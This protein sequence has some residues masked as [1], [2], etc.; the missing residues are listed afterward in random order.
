MGYVVS[1]MQDNAQG[2]ASR[3]SS[4][5]RRQSLPIRVSSHITTAVII[6]PM[7][8]VIEPQTYA[9]VL[10][11]VCW[12]AGPFQPHTIYD[13]DIRARIPKVSSL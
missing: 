2:L 12:A 9:V 6:L 1:L 7:I 5:Y 3:Q 8:T 10:R 4:V 13:V 11:A